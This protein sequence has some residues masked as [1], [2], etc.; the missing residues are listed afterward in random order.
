MKKLVLLFALLPLAVSCK[1]NNKSAAKQMGA[2]EVETMQEMSEFQAN[3]LF[4]MAGS[5][6]FLN[7]KLYTCGEFRQY[8]CSTAISGDGT[9]YGMSNYGESLLDTSL[10]F[11]PEGG[12]GIA[13]IGSD[14]DTWETTVSFQ[15]FAMY[16]WV[17][18]E[19][20]V[21][22]DSCD[23]PTLQY[24]QAGER[25]ESRLAMDNGIVYTA[26]AYMR[27]TVGTRYKTLGIIRFS[28]GADRDETAFCEPTTEMI[29]SYDVYDLVFSFDGNAPELQGP[30]TFE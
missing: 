30:W 10:I 23:N 5:M 29:G 3:G 18:D 2:K 24:V 28:T 17:N 27:G 9:R 7:N 21:L 25:A 13:S 11:W 22:V 16:R 1:D 8:G 15:G 12:Y 26:G 20:R 6:S 14:K 19:N 4:K